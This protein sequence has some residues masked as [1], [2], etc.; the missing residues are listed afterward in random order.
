MQNQLGPAFGKVFEVVWLS[1]IMNAREYTRDFGGG[2]VYVFCGFSEK[3]ITPVS[4]HV[5]LSSPCKCL[6]NLKKS[7]IA[8]S[9]KT[10][11]RSGV[12]V[13]AFRFSRWGTR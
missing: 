13:D 6:A 4:K 2:Y 10:T 8:G 9:I 11:Q 3:R 7:K 1:R 12:P 5:P